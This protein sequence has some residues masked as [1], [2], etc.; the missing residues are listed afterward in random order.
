MSPKLNLE[1]QLQELP[2]TKREGE[3]G[4]EKDFIL[5][6]QRSDWHACNIG[7]YRNA[8]YPDLIER[9]EPNMKTMYDV[10]RRGT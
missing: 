3:T 4:M 6:L 5:L 9:I 8:L 1:K 2:N 7:I 10:F